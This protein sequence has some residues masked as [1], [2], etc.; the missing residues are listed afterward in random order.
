[1]MKF[2]PHCG[3]SRTHDEVHTPALGSIAVTKILTPLLQAQLHLYSTSQYRRPS[4]NADEVVHAH[5]ADSAALVLHAAIPTL[6]VQCRQRGSYTY[7]ELNCTC[8]PR[9]NT[10]AHLATQTK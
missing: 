8:T 6:I 4:C 1:M 10:G 7:C 2:T 5:T 9:R 3:L